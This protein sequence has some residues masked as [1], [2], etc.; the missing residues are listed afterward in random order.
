M[1]RPERG[2]VWEHRNGSV[3]T[4]VG[5]TNL[6]TQNEEKY[7]VTVI[8]Q[9]DNGRSWSRPLSEWFRSMTEAVK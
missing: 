5:F 3:Y 2:S 4:V 7:P 9:G 1:K 6:H 8:Y